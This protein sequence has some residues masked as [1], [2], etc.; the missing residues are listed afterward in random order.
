MLLYELTKLYQRFVEQGKLSADGWVDEKV[1]FG[2]LLREDGEIEQILSLQSED[3][4]P[5]IMQVPQHASRTSDINAFFLWDK[6][7][8]LLGLGEEKDEKRVLQCFEASKARHLEVLKDV[9]SPAAE[10][11]K[12]Y[13]Q[14]H[15]PEDAG[16]NPEIVQNREALLKGN[17]CFFYQGKPVAE[18]EEIRRAWQR[19]L[20]T[21]VQGETGICMVTGKRSRIE[22]LHPLIKGVAGAQSS[23]AALVSF[24]A[25]A[26]N[27]YG[28]ES[29]E[30]AP[31]SEEAARAYGAALNY[32]LADRE[33]VY[34]VG[35]TTVVG[36]ACSGE[37]EPWDILYAYL[38]GEERMQDEDVQEALRALTSGRAICWKQSEVDPHEQFCILGLAPNAGR[39]SLR[40]FL[41]DEFGHW[42]QNIREHEARLEIVRPSG[43]E[44]ESLPYWKI[45][46]E[47]KAPGDKDKLPL[48]SAQLLQAVLRDTPYP[49]ELLYCTVRRVRADHEISWRRMA[50]LKAYLLKNS[51]NIE[52][53]EEWELLNEE[54]NNQAY[55]LG[56][57]FS[58]LEETQE[59]SVDSKLNTTIKDRYFNSACSTPLLVF[60]QLM[61][62]RESHMKKLKRDK[63]KTAVSLDK[64]FMELTGRIDMDIPKQ[65]NAEEQAMFMLGYY[66]QTQKKYQ[67]KEEE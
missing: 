43:A 40:F 41:K 36:W 4:K 18:D 54:S 27:S 26:F 19:C 42:L 52:K 29:G 8:Y 58:V 1:S 65:L 62:L 63:P 50:V 3:K 57:L 20:E 35:D 33:H 17:L 64:R 44:K 6:S 59:S 48:L 15:G 24:N 55:L 51:A 56:R 67:K 61:K 23:G 60:S 25:D 9:C 53:K 66:H 28:M 32:L 10:A 21:D 11:V 38:Q 2:I 7:K 47:L 13:Y 12:R 16:S 22:R 49:D 37:E 45:I 46:K 5:R 14:D 34:R 31:T 30:N 39:L